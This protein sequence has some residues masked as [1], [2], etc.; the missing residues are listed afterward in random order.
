MGFDVAAVQQAGVSVGMRS[1]HTRITRASGKLKVTSSPGQTLLIARVELRP[2]QQE[3]AA[4][5]RTA[6]AAGVAASR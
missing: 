5:H 2:A 4:S 1:M 6:D 3:A